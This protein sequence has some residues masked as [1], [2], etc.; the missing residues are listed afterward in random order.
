MDGLQV[1]SVDALSLDEAL[2]LAREL[3]HLREL[4]QGTLPGVDRDTS[5]RLALGVLTVAQGHPKLLEL[6]DG[7]AADP[8]RL[9]ALV[10]AGD[11]AWR[12]AGGLP[13]GFFA[14][15]HADATAADY[16]HVL[17]AWTNM[18]G[19]TL[20]PRERTL[21][22]FLCSLEEP[23]RERRVLDANWDGL[24]NRLGGDGPP[25]EL[26]GALR[27]IAGR[28]LIAVRREPESYAI[29]P[30]VVA[31]A[32]T[33]AGK[34]FRDAVDTETA[35]S[36]DAAFRRAS[37]EIGDD[38]IDTALMVHAG[39]AAVPYLLRQEQWA[40]A[41]Q[42]LERAFIADPSRA[43]AAAMLPAIQ[44]IAARDPGHAAAAARVLQAIDPAAAEAQL[45]ASLDAVAARGDFPV[46]S[47]AAG[48]LI[49][50]CVSGG[51][52]AE[53]LALADRKIGYTR[54]A[55][56]GPWSQLADEG[57]R[58]QVLNAMGQADRVLG[59]V[60]RLR[61]R[62]QTLPDAHS[63][64]EAVRPWNVR[65]ALLDIGRSAAQRLGRWADALDLNA[66]QTASMR[67]RRAPAAV[68]ARA[69]FN[70]YLPLFQLGRTSE[71]LDLLLEC[72]QA[73]QDANDIEGLGK[74]L[75]ALATIE[76]VR[77]HSDVASLMER[78]ALRY[79]YLTGDVTAIA[80]SYD[81]LGHHLHLD[82]REP[83][84]ALA[85]HLT[86]ALIGALSGADAGHPSV[87]AAAVDLRAFGPSATPP[88]DVADLLR[89]VGDIPGAD[90]DRLL[91]ALAPDPAAIEQALRDLI[92]Q[93]QA[94]AAATLPE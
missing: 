67:D 31:A 71:A 27:A 65:E 88:A 15:G 49:N 63:P 36:W 3:P 87:R 76:D 1:E 48:R 16:L 38:D 58:L 11:Q 17:A 29:H 22:W 89:L 13:S 80:A 34:P 30:G 42:L 85:C 43:N 14:T 39:L 55:G 46:A 61:D 84:S 82:A 28:G 4:I 77:G 57:M 52:L 20:A 74:A 6:A 79:K 56:L 12:E 47:V 19:S 5:R 60:E 86:A 41:A 75:G 68:I 50:L 69:R 26:D 59:E 73:F 33:Q 44:E 81:N 92:T 90:L 91:A 93:A 35:A 54:Q 24:W 45:R 78:D 21:F 51:R 64:V 94:E 8:A 10:A 53:A 32:R 23:D 40:Q 62:M 37:G 66:A 83:A 25:P 70:D 72:R 2:L 7:Q 9:A 18:V